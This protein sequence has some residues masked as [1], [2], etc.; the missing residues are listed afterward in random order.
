VRTITFPIDQKALTDLI[1]AV[2]AGTWGWF[3]QW[4]MFI[5][6]L[7]TLGCLAWVFIDSAQKRRGS[8]ALVPRILS[9]VGVLLV[10]PAF[11]FRFT[12]NVDGTTVQLNLLD[13]KGVA[14]YLYTQPVGW[15]VQWLVAGY[16]PTL[17]LL[18]FVGVVLG[19][20]ALIIYA[21]TV[22]R[23]RPSTE[24]I[25]A[26]NSQFGQIRQEIQATRPVTGGMAPV[27]AVA[28]AA[29]P[30]RSAATVMSG[31][32]GRSAPTV[33]GAPAQ[34][35]FAELW[36][37]SGGA[38]SQRW[39]LPTVDV[40]IGRETTN[41]VSIDDERASREHAKIRFA[42][43]VYSLIDLGSSNGTLLN[44]QLVQ[45]PSRLNDGDVIRIGSTALT[46]KTT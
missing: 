36:L 41:L 20:L 4:G 33:M 11:L 34:P 10:I 8:K 14:G 26:L 42:D 2:T 6:F 25:N 44:D 45:A 17:A 37:V 29:E 5:F 43:G 24:F 15:N 40:K 22:S 30:R 38:V 1:S 9:I 18:A 19:V 13:A 32:P 28:G 27:A 12:G 35:G 21:S 46:F 16:G 31:Q 3:Y 7:V 39:S 23:S